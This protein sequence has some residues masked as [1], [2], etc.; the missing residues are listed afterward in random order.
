[1]VPEALVLGIEEG[2]PDV[3]GVT[4]LG[5]VSVAQFSLGPVAVAVLPAFEQVEESGD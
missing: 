3:Q 4:H 2:N 1:M 5:G